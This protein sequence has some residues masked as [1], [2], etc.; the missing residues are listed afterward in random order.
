LEAMNRE[1]LDTITFNQYW[2]ERAN[3][4]WMT[5]NVRLP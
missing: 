5:R 4:A 1:N 2:A 3:P